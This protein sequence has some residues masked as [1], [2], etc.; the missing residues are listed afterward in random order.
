MHVVHDSPAGGLREAKKAETRR[1]LSSAARAL[2]RAR[3]LDGVTV[4]LV[5]AEVGVSVRTFFNYFE[6]KESAVLGDAPPLGTPAARAAFLDGGPSGDLLADL[7]ALLDPSAT[8]A[9]EGRAGLRASL[10]LAEREP[11]L[12]ARHLARQMA[13]EQE[14]AHLVAERRGLPAADAT[15]R[16]VA[17]VAHAVVRSACHEWFEAEDGSALHDHLNR[18][19]SDAAA[20]LSTTPDVRR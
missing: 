11:R 7:V 14:L 5:C 1:Q 3:G 8:V 17:A 6:S 10:E 13:H 18:A 4:E 12:L 20:A 16:C 9:Q 19:R 15:C 2:A